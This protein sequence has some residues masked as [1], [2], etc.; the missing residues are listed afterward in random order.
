MAQL[1]VLEVK[2]RDT[3]GKRRVRR[4]RATGMVPANL[5]GHKQET[6]NLMIDEAAMK[7]ILRRGHQIVKLTGASSDEALIKEVQWNVWGNEILHVDFTRINANETVKATVPVVLKGDAAGLREGGVIETLIHEVEVECS[8]FNM[9]ENI[10]ISVT[11]LGLGQQITAADLKLPEGVTTDLAADTVMV[12]CVTK[13]EEVDMT[14]A[15]V[16]GAEPEV[17][18]RKKADEEV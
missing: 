11:N 3:F 16:D 17:I 4:L 14:S 15:V 13:Q 1:E 7:M 12:V 8:A 6:V 9:P 18:A 5:Y 10:V 2:V